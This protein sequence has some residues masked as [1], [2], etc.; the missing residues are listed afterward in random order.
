[1]FGMFFT[2]LEKVTCFRDVADHCDAQRFNTF[3]HA[4]LKEG[5]YL[6]PSSFEAGFMSIAHSEQDIL[7]TIAA[8]D[9]VMAT[10]K[11]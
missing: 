6:A 11:N 4:M 2:E 5:V 3:F 9:R 8:A 1:M 7:E 10:L